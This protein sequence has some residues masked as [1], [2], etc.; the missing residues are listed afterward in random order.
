MKTRANLIERTGR[1]YMKTLVAYGDF[2]RVGIVGTA[3]LR[4][5]EDGS[6]NKGTK[7]AGQCVVGLEEYGGF[8]AQMVV[9]ECSCELNEGQTSRSFGSAG[10]RSQADRRRAANS[11]G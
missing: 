5:A 8:K 9:N 6:L 3:Q 4:Q 10:L 11:Q 2:G 1:Q 7:R